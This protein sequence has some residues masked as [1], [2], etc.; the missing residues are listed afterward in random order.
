MGEKIYT[1]GDVQASITEFVFLRIRSEKSKIHL[2]NIAH[3]K[4]ECH[5]L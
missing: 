3:K 4:M 5:S 1:F 2:R